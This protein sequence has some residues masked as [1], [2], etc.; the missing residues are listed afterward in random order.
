MAKRNVIL[1]TG[2]PVT[3]PEDVF[4]YTKFVD[5]AAYPT[6]SSFEYRHVEGRDIFNRVTGWKDLDTLNDNFLYNSCRA[7]RRE[8]D[9]DLPD[10]TYEPIF[11][12]LVPKHLDVYNKLAEEALLL[13]DENEEIDFLTQSGL[14]NALQQVIIGYSEYLPDDVKVTSRKDIAALHLLDSIMADMGDR[15]LLVFA[16]YKN[17][18]ETI[19]EHSSKYGAVAVNGTLTTKQRNENIDKFV[20]DPDCKMLIGQPLSMGSGLDS[21]KDVCSDILFLE[22]PMVSKDFVQ[23]VGRI[24][25]NGQQNRCH[26][27]IAVANKTVQVRRQEALLRK[28]EVANVVQNPPINYKNLRDWIYGK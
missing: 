16:W 8:I 11:Y 14:Q 6:F 12:D 28:D 1:M 27:K 5:P 24:D 10:V 23:A 25:R 17:S 19:L 15:K 18:I 13:I 26:V 20:N 9:M 21:L 4:G 2:T 22:L 3:T 7:F